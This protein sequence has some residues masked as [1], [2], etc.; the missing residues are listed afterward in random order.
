MS[1]FGDVHSESLDRREHN[2]PAS[3]K[4]IVAKGFDSVSGTFPTLNVD[5][6]GNLQIEGTFSAGEPGLNRRVSGTLGALGDVL[7]INSQ[8]CGGVRWRVEAGL[9]GTIVFQ[10]TIDPTVADNDTSAAWFT[11]E[12]FFI[13]GLTASSNGLFPELGDLLFNAMHRVRLRVSVYSSGSSAARMEASPVANV[14]RSV[15]QGNLP[16]GSVAESGNPVKIGGK[17]NAAAPTAVSEGT[18]VEA[19]YDLQGRQRVTGDVAA[20][21]PVAGTVANDAVDSGNSV[22]VGG[23]AFSGTP[24]AVADADRVDARFTTRGH[25]VVAV[26]DNAGLIA[27]TFA[28]SAGR[29]LGVFIDQES[30]L[31]HVATVGL[32]D[33]VGN[34]AHDAVDSGDPVKIGGKANTSPPTAVAAGDR[35]DAFFDANGRLTVRIQNANGAD[36]LLGTEADNSSNPSSS[37]TVRSDTHEFDGSTWDRIRHSFKQTTTGIT[38]TGAGTTLDMTTTPM[39]KFAIMVDR[40]A[41]A[42]AFVVNLEGSIDGTNW[43][44]LVA[45]SAVDGDTTFVVDK[46]VDRIRYNVTTIGAGNTLTIVIFA[47]G[48]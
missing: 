37:L 18:R 14:I 35:V 31:G 12:T 21:V 46:P 6:D 4:S 26:G 2:T 33:V 40:T 20:P 45:H 5:S 28:I 41:G 34:V 16:P 15:V 10:G 38:G 9:S 36:I 17:A 7:V 48:R 30:E 25:Q 1:G 44:T 8:G 39:S 27:D 47:S 29:A 19:S 11:I 13:K 32:A 3:A 24:T 43:S 42:S 22:K 23:K